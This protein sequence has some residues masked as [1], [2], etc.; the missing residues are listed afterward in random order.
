MAFSARGSARIPELADAPP[1]INTAVGNAVN[2]LDKMV[3][4]QYATTAA[5]DLANPTPVEGWVCYVSVNAN[6]GR[7]LQVYQDGAWVPH[8]RSAI[9]VKKPS[10]AG[11]RLSGAGIFA[12]PHLVLP[13]KA[14]ADY[15][16]EFHIIYYGDAGADMGTNFSFPA[17]AS[18]IGLGGTGPGTSATA[19]I[20]SGEWLAF[21]SD[22][23]SPTT[24]LQYGSIT[25]LSSRTKATISGLCTVGATPGSL[26][27][28][29]GNT[30]HPSNVVEVLA[31]SYCWAQRMA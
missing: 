7:T 1:N 26:V 4:P 11:G 13:L 21:E 27:F 8:F 24:N 25:G 31:G 18:I 16:F 2:D 3:I 23:S 5:R 19:T 22:T 9:L 29:W 20:A 15:H 10:S 6:Q 17:G 14:N 12:D 28:N 30:S